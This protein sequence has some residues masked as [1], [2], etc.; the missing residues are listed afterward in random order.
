MAADEGW[1]RRQQPAGR[2]EKVSS[3][4]SAP[5]TSRPR[6]WPF[7]WAWPGDAASAAP[8][9]PAA[10]GAGPPERPRITAIPRPLTATEVG[11]REVAAALP[12]ALLCT[13]ALLIIPEPVR[14]VG[15]VLVATASFEE[16]PPRRDVQPIPDS[17]LGEFQ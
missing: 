2:V 6:R 8:S 12:D 17:Q 14:P 16:A 7:C 4:A 13:S 10:R 1:T 15:G 5:S 11:T 9:Q 3:P